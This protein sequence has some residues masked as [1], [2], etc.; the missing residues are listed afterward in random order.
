[1]AQGKLKGQAGDEM[2]QNKYADLQSTLLGVQFGQATGANQSL[3]QT[4]ANMLSAKQ[5]AAAGNRS[6]MQALT[7]TLLDT[8]LDKLFT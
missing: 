7:N 6:S 2:V 8:D 4:K 5:S 3:Q 1:M